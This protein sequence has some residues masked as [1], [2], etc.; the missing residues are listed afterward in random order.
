MSPEVALDDTLQHRAI[1]LSRTLV[2]AAQSNNMAHYTLTVRPPTL[3]RSLPRP[4]LSLPKP[5]LS[6]PKP[7]LSLPKPALEL[8]EGV[9]SLENRKTLS[10]SLTPYT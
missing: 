1:L 8:A 3:T 6:L 7:A 4:A 5:A 2:Q 9:T 10:L